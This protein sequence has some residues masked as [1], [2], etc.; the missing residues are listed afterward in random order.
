M[1][2]TRAPEEQEQQQPSPENNNNN[3][4]SGENN[5]GVQKKPKID[6]AERISQITSALDRHIED[7]ERSRIEAQNKIEEVCNALR[8]A[9][10]VLEDR[11][12]NTVEK[13][14][15]DEE[16]R[17]QESVHKLNT[18][19]GMILSN[20]EDGMS[21]D[22]KEK[23]LEEIEGV[24]CGVQRYEVKVPECDDLKEWASNTL[25]SEFKVNVHQ[26]L[27]EEL[28]RGRAFR[29]TGLNEVNSNEVH[30]MTSFLKA[31]EEAAM[32]K[33]KLWSGVDYVVE[34]WNGEEGNRKCFRTEQVLGPSHNAYV[35]WR[36]MGGDECKIRGRA[37]W[38]GLSGEECQSE[39][40]EW[41]SFTVHKKHKNS[42]TFM[43]CAV[44]KKRE[45]G[46]SYTVI[47]PITGRVLYRGMKP[48]TRIPDSSRG[49]E[50]LIRGEKERR[51]WEEI[52]IVGDVPQDPENLLNDLRIFH[53][54]GD[55]CVRALKEM[56]KKIISTP[57]IID[58]VY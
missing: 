17:L 19:S 21:D 54:D 58:F 40:S 2:R 14:Y 49:H 45:V 34:M 51:R 30:I 37:I 43:T 53:T 12:R 52:I 23:R 55:A 56:E 3:G 22:E 47:D 46:E 32:R 7:H 24:L 5:E 18:L 25:S 4:T 36:F 15:P 48:Y 50:L 31:E 57:K 1:K 6:F 28:L 10:D 27:S 26:S 29:I 42:G 38:R 11:L 35:E 16:T 9:V 44:W 13:W 41:K 39:W 8:E 33:M 20:A